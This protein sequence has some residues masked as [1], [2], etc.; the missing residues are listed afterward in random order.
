VPRTA[1]LIG[2]QTEMLSGVGND[3]AAMA[4]ALN[5]WEFTPVLCE[6]EDASRAGILDAYERLI[7]GTRPEDAVVV[8]YSGHGGYSRN[9]YERT[10]RRPIQFIVPTDFHSSTD[11]DF[12]GITAAELSLL[13]ARLTEKTK[14]ATVVLDCCHSA[15]MSR[16]PDWTV[17]STGLDV[18]YGTIAAHLDSLRQRGQQLDLWTPPG[19]PNAVRIVA[20]APEQVAYEYRNDNGVRTGMLTDLLAQ[21]LT[22]AR[23]VDVSWA[24]IIDG[25]RQRV[26][27]RAPRQRP[28]AEGP[29][30]RLLFDVVDTDPVATLP[31]AMVAGR[32]RISGAALLGVRS[33]DEFV[34]MP[35]DVPGPDNHRKIGDVRVDQLDS[36]AAWGELRPAAP[37][38]PV[39][40][41]AHLASTAAL[42][43][44]VRMTGPRSAAL[45][46][47]IDA[48]PL[49]RLAE[50]GPVQVVVDETGGA[51]VRDEIGPL[52]APR[53][54]DNGGVAAVLRDL[55]RLA[56]ARALRCLAEETG[57]GLRTPVTVEFGQV[58]NLR[59][60]PL[61]LSGAVLYVDEPIYVR[62][63]NED[64]DPVYVSLLDIGV[65]AQITVLN[66]S[67]PSGVL[68]VRGEEFVFGGDSAADTVPGVPLS[69]PT[70]LLRGQ[71]RP[72]TI[73]VLATSAPVDTRVL[74]QQG[75]RVKGPRSQLQRYLDQ[76]STGG[77]RDMS[78]TPGPV[79]RFSVRTIDFD[80]TPTTAPP[81]EAVS[82]QVD[83]RL[84]MALE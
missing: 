13:L 19:N 3:V 10:E 46:R 56:M 73:V 54:A 61:P 24:T 5:L 84:D 23:A 76:V 40:A 9:P 70:G 15:H 57:Q 51:T 7:A 21:A 28:E 31:A 45:A 27:G 75:V 43:M 78:P 42:T 35:G 38:L 11:G 55:N 36:E 63:R 64:K 39:N 26:L 47:A 1:L 25:V 16:D 30:H 59:P 80:L 81:A 67:S 44:P 17:K 4:E 32:I 49:V 2:A 72:E 8:Y 18:P 53:R 69:W 82:L 37:A 71:P 79:V 58:E 22:Q 29:A 65:T 60:R 33:G 48:A 14:N 41:R 52:H 83:D 68:L 62:V 66:P 20:C 77:R 50:N 12:R 6:G 74:E 34:V